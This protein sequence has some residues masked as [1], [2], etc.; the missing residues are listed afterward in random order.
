M[1]IELVFGVVMAIV[2][3]LFGLLFKDSLV[4]SRYIP[5][6]NL[7]IGIVAAILAIVFGLFETNGMAIMTCLAIAMGV[8]GAYDLS[9]T[10]HKK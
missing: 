5:L 3:Y 9:Q 10:T 6:Q 7:I 2:T 4:P 8:G 1:T